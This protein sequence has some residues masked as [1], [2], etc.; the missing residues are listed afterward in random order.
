M[1]DEVAVA[2]RVDQECTKRPEESTKLHRSE[3]GEMGQVS[4][5]SRFAECQEDSWLA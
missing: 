1:I 3:V 4:D 5:G 2:N